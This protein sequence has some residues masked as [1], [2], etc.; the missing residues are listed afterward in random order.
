[1]VAADTYSKCGV[2]PRMMTPRATTASAPPAKAAWAATAS[3]N[4]PGTRTR[5]CAAPDSSS[6]RWALVIM[7]FV[8]VSCQVP[9]TMTTRRPLPSMGVDGVVL[10][11]QFTMLLAGILGVISVTGEYSTG[12]I[13]ST[14]TAVPRRGMVLA[15]KAVVMAVLMFVASMVIFFAAALVVTPMLAG[16]SSAIDWSDVEGTILPILASSASMAVF[17]LIGVAVGFLLRSGAGAIAAVVGLLFVLPIV[18]QMFSMAGEGWRW[19][20]DLALYLPSSA[21]Q[22]AI[23]PSADAPLDG[24][25]ASLT[26]VA[27]VAGTM[28]AAWGVLRTR[29][30]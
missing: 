23:I 27:W 1:M 21:A 25:S 14:L 2:P 24:T 18:A 8:I 9:A 10:P 4:D 30:A 12:M 3:S 15:A 28:L 16:T 13:R 22:F 7:A 29:D 5:L 11:I 20:T 17:S 6:T 26:L 19:V